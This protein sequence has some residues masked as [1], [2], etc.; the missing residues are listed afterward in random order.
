MTMVNLFDITSESDHKELV[1]RM[2]DNGEWEYDRLGIGIDNQGTFLVCI[3]DTGE[4]IRK[5]WYVKV[6]YV[7][8]LN[9]GRDKGLFE[10]YSVTDMFMDGLGFEEL[11]KEVLI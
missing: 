9:W 2:A 7:E 11:F 10:E 4:E 8:L 5:K 3:D 6:N 1:M